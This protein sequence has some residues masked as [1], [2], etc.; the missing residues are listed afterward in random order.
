MI[1]TAILNVAL[2]AF[3]PL[4]GLLPVSHLA[5][6]DVSSALD[7]LEGFDGLVPVLGPLSLALGVLAAVVVFFTIRA[8]LFVWQQVKW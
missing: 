3:S 1:T 4:F 7:K 8:V 2:G 6:P 5:L